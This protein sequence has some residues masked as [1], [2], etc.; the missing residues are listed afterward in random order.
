MR[1]LLVKNGFNE[2]INYPFIGNV[3]E[4]SISI[5][6][7]IDSNKGFMRTRIRESLIDNLLYNERR[8]KDSIKLFEFS[9]IY[10]SNSTKKKLG[11]LRAEDV[12]IIMKNSQNKLIRVILNVYSIILI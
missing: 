3:R 12:D 4:D 6:N 8:Q 1:N 5:D 2:V 11:S 7:P 10:T 9:D